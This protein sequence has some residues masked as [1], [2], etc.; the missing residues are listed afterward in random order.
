MILRLLILV[1]TLTVSTILYSQQSGYMGKTVAVE[2]NLGLSPSLSTGFIGNTGTFLSIN[3]SFYIEK[4]FTE[5]LSFALSYKTQDVFVPAKKAGLEIYLDKVNNAIAYYGFK[6]DFFIS[7]K[8]FTLSY[9]QY[10]GKANIA[11]FGSYFRFEFGPSFYSI[12]KKNSSLVLQADS[13]YDNSRTIVYR[14]FKDNN[15]YVNLNF[16]VNYGLKRVI[17]NNLY[18]T[19][20]VGVNLNVLTVLGLLI[21]ASIDFTEDDFIRRTGRRYYQWQNLTEVKIGLGYFLF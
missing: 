5:D 2:Y 18:L 7:Y 8:T 10:S 13:G 14:D 15:T 21:D 19:A 11:P 20:N 1:I 17:I 16:H 3:H 9:M 6:N 4:S 12:S